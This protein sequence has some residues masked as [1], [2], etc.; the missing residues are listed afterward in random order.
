MN[1]LS[2]N[3]VD[4]NF[5]LNFASTTGGNI[6]SHLSEKSDI[7]RQQ[8]LCP[9]E[10]QDL[11]LLDDSIATEMQR[12][13][14]EGLFHQISCISDQKLARFGLKHKNLVHQAHFVK[15]IG[16]PGLEV[17]MPCGLSTDVIE[18]FLRQNS[19]EIFDHWLA[20]G[21]LYA[22]HLL[23][24]NDK[25]CP[26]LEI[27]EAAA[28]LHAI[29]KAIVEAFSKASTDDITY[30]SLGISPEMELW[31]EE[32]NKKGHYLMVRSSGAE[33]SSHAA[34]AGGN[35]SKAYVLPK[36]GPLCNAIGEVVSSY[37]SYS[38]LQNRINVG[39]NPFFEELNIGLTTQELIGECLGGE[40]V[41][42]DIPVS[43]V[44]FTNEPLYVGDEKFRVMRLS[45]TYGHGNGVVGGADAIP[46]DT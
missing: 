17:P 7:L 24:P 30:Q 31:L 33:D 14:S 29:E 28:H 1:K 20:L 10:N 23:I 18:A 26:F 39:I 4:F 41:S 35:V 19:P 45:A 25:E 22:S 27:P 44:L 42:S 36:T 3:P 11:G 2:F 15:S 46:T 40:K 9:E 43:L 37:F 5:R 21:K 38:S 34:N 13:E 8:L 12:L 16:I 32:S 6:F